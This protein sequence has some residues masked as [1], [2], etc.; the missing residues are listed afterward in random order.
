MQSAERFTKQ[1]CEDTDRRV[2]RCIVLRRSGGVLACLT[3]AGGKC[4][5]GESEQ[6]RR[7][8]SLTQRSNCRKL[9]L[10]C[11]L[12]RRCAD[13]CFCLSEARSLRASKTNM[14]FRAGLARG[15][16]GA[17]ARLTAAN[18]G[19]RNAFMARQGQNANQVYSFTKTAT[20]SARIAHCFVASG[21]C[22]VCSC[23]SMLGPSN[24]ARP[25]AD[26]KTVNP[27]DLARQK[28]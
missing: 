23:S 4:S 21:S 28:H 1:S 8:R 25:R 17:G 6:R 27:L 19:E 24:N 10:C 20:A 26:Q 2:G 5:G 18:A 7:R 3:T 16:G 22:C 15:M 13:Q 14:D 11:V 12:H 9:C